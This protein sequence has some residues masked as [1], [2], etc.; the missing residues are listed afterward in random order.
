M[1]TRPFL[2]MLATVAVAAT[3]LWHYSQT[4][5]SDDAEF[6]SWTNADGS[7]DWEILM[8]AESWAEIKKITGNDEQRQKR[9]LM[10]VI[11][12]AFDS[13]ELEGNHCRIRGVSIV[14]L[15]RARIVGSCQPVANVRAPTKL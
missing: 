8:P 2:I 6:V 9:A 5:Q 4:H 7:F 3:A 15:N 11:T 14:T 10:I 12:R 13:S 1:Q